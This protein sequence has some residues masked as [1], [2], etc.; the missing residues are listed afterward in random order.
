MRRAPDGEQGEE[1][2]QEFQIVHEAPGVLGKKV[3]SG[4]QGSALE[5]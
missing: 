4:A 5:V 2:E 3:G 1:A